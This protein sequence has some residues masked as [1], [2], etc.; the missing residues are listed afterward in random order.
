MSKLAERRQQLEDL[1][2][3]R[4]VGSKYKSIIEY[5]GDSEELEIDWDELEELLEI[6]FE[7]IETILQEME[8]LGLIELDWTNQTI[9]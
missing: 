8:D 2:Y 9:W 4:G 3:T 7:E 1:G 5:I 6:N